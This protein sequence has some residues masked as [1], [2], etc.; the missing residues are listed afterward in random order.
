VLLSERGDQ[1]CTLFGIIQPG[2]T[3]LVWAMSKD[4][5][6]G[7]YNC[8]FDGPIWNNDKRDPAVLFDAQGRVVDRR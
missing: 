6:Q 5:G 7:G 4:I 1:A 3:L 2:E 8:G